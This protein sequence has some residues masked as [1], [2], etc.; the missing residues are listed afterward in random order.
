MFR[1]GWACGLL[2]LFLCVGCG[3]RNNPKFEKTVPVRGKVVLANGTPVAGGL[4]TF[5]HKDPTK[6]AAWGTIG[7]DGSFELGMYKK[8]DGAIPGTYTVIV[9]PIVFDQNGN[10]RPNKSLGIPA[11]YTKAESSDL[12][13]EVKDEGDQEMKLVL[14]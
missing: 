3:P 14:R 9:E 11:K 7:R 5:R 8:N 13:V 2:A 1:S 12:T 4:I 10:P 6:G